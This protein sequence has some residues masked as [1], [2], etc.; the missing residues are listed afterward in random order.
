MKVLFA[1][2]NEEISESV[3]KRYQ[4]EYKEIIS[5][6]NVYF[7]NAILKEIQKDKSYD[8]IVIS[9]D[10]EVFTHTQY[11]QIDKFLF[12]K[13]DSISDEASN[14]KGDDIPII[15]ICSDRRTKSEQI[16]SKLFGI[17]IY[18]AIIGN[19][20]S[21]EEVCNL[22]RK[23][24]SK[25]EAKIYYKID[26]E[27]VGYEK[28]DK[29]EV[30]ETEMQNILAHYKRLG[31]DEEKYVQSF[32]S[33][34]AQYNDTQ[35]RII[36]RYL[37]LNVRAVLEEKSEKYQK[38]MAFNS[39]VSETL[40]KPKKEQKD[41]E[42]HTEKL[43]KPKIREINMS[44]PVVIPSE[45]NM[46]GNKKLSKNKQGKINIETQE[47]T[48]KEKNQENK[49]NEKNA[50]NKLQTVEP[51]KNIEIPKE[52]IEESVN[53]LDT[54]SNENQAS[55]K[56]EESVKPVKRGRGRPKKNPE[57][58]ENKPKRGRGRPKKVSMQNEENISLPGF[59]TIKE[60]KD[61][62]ETILPGVED[63]ILESVT[64]EAKRD[65]YQNETILPGFENEEISQEENILPGFEEDFEN[66]SQNYKKYQDTPSDYEENESNILPG[67][68]EDEDEDTSEEL[69]QEK[70]TSS[71]AENENIMPGLENSRNIVE[72]SSN[73][74]YYTS[75]AQELLKPKVNENIDIANLI[76][77]DK[78]IVCFVGTSKNGTS[79]IVNNIAQ[80]LSARGI[81]TA[82]L[83][84]TKNRNSYYIYTKNEEE[85]R[86]IASTTLENLVYGSAEGIDAGKNLKV[87]TSMPTNDDP[88]NNSREILQ[89]LIQKHSCILIDCDFTTP[90]D[91]FKQAQEIYLVQS[92]DVLTIQPLTAFLRELKAQNILEERKI[93]IVLN[94]AIKVKGVNERAIIGGMAFYNDP[95]MSFMTELF[96]RNIVKYI[97]IPFSEEVYSRYLSSLVECEISQ[98]GYP[99]YI[100][101]ALNEL[102]NMVYPVVSGKSTYKPPT[103]K[104][105]P[106]F[107]QSMNST[108]D[109]MRK[110]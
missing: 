7:F 97:S 54:S 1:V 23:P 61:T 75:R 100:M 66:S 39:K 82:I 16:L 67:F 22:I 31:K 5:Y 57:P 79:F 95:S 53:V 68:E 27:E 14:A 20:R 3:V 52:Q 70:N 45:V 49:I 15:L 17:G 71:T 6:K 80:I 84:A 43:L 104:K 29:N 85:L 50:Q 105:V 9:E 78:K 88:I 4:R 107:T 86:N 37:P 92:L 48:I 63:D 110:Y 81:D 44:K 101:Q 21:V 47:S 55:A 103:A 30:S 64:P 77:S 90:V 72:P 56:I 25:K 89:T 28:E 73:Q 65:T 32:D 10:L 76:T 2:S 87:Y 12:E 93:K 91:Y 42:G 98:K 24:R 26:T 41:T 18:N 60:N 11:D 62:S 13:L 19:D 58:I 8:R 36:C 40:R 83:D 38:L 109:Q 46:Q 99:K 94:K 96:D 74:N 102:A 59:E 33:I 51:Q 34:A 69:E 35:L 106:T 108:L